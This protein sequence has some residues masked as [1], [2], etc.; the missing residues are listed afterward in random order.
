MSHA[1]SKLNCSL[2]MLYTQMSYFMVIKVYL[3]SK[4][5]FSGNFPEIKFYFRKI[6]KIYYRKFP[7][8][9]KTETSSSYYVFTRSTTPSFISWKSALGVK[10]LWAIGP[11]C[12]F[13]MIPR[14]TYS[15]GFKVRKSKHNILLQNWPFGVACRF[16]YTPR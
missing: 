16:I 13:K 14:Y 12:R 4:K 5:S 2:I 11:A 3:C 15:P 1:C 9:R 6:L 7:E 8:F 10:V